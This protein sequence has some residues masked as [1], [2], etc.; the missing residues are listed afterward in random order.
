MSQGA[1]E[2]R[3]KRIRYSGRGYWSIVEVEATDQT[4]ILAKGP[5]PGIYEGDRIR[6]VGVWENDPKWG[7]QFAV[8]SMTKQERNGIETVLELLP[9]VGPKR[10]AQIRELFS[11][12]DVFIV[13]EHEPHRLKAIPGLTDERIAEIRKVCLDRKAE[14]DLLLWC[15]SNGV[16]AYHAGLIWTRFGDRA[17]SILKSQPYDVVQADGVGFLTADRIARRAGADPNGRERAQAAIMFVLSEAEAADG[18]TLVEAG[19]MMAALKGRDRGPGGHAT[20]VQ[21]SPPLGEDSIYA[22][23][24]DL[25]TA[26]QIYIGGGEPTLIQRA[27]TRNI[28]KSI[29][30][31]LAAFALRPAALP[32][33]ADDDDDSRDLDDDMETYGGGV[34]F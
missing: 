24:S 33:G 21:M 20:A 30:K 32:A 2:G 28:E 9:D 17:M 16:S 6:A 31:R 25:R 22:A 8:E 3:V 7:R 13:I 23:L 14:R 10:A 1:V 29:A 12:E 11:T 15:G 26:R 19:M 27:S 34:P 4:V 5:M 18:S